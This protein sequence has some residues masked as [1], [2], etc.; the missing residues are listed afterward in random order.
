MKKLLMLLL[1]VLAFGLLATAKADPIGGPGSPC[2]TCQGATYTLFTDFVDTNPLAGFETYRVSLLIDTS[3]LDPFGAVAID[4][5]AIKIANSINNALL[6]SF[7][8]NSAGWLTSINTGLDASGC[9]GGG[10]GFLCSQTPIDPAEVGGTLEWIFDITLAAGDLIDPASIKVRYIDANGDKIGD[11]VS[12]NITLQESPCVPGTPGCR[13]PFLIV[14][15]PSSLA[16]LALAVLAAGAVNR[17]RR[18]G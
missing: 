11:L 18:N 3:T 6:I 16:L 4:T 1:S 12:E 15:E 10:S 9:S 13:P 14:P 2:A 7:P 17:R 8:P 5:I